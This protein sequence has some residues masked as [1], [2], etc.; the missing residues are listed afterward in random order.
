MT[1]R[2]S[3]RSGTCVPGPRPWPPRSPVPGRR[4]ATWSRRPVRD[5]VSSCGP[6]PAW[7]RSPGWPGPGRPDQ[8][9]PD[10]LPARRM[11][12]SGRPDLR[13]APSRQPSISAARAF[14]LACFVAQRDAGT[15][16][17]TLRAAASS[18]ALAAWAAAAGSAAAYPGMAAWRGLARGMLLGWRPS[19]DRVQ[20]EDTG[21]IR[22][23][24]A[25][26]SA[27]GVTGYQLRR[28]MTVA[29]GRRLRTEVPA[30]WQSGRPCR[31][32]PDERVLRAVGWA[33]KCVAWAACV[34]LS[35]GHGRI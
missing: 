5:S 33:G 24:L 14:S 23:V 30:P 13:S 9:L 12:E 35:S 2:M 19:P 28:R 16:R 1:G 6:A 4:P 8:H 10:V 3:L 22:I 32:H 15:G 34:C 17:R 11:P 18:C 29:C 21:G 27:C 26:V 31:R 20:I 25:G 7:P